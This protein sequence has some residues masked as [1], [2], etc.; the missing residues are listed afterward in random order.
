[1]IPLFTNFFE[2][3]RQGAF[4]D[5]S[6]RTVRHFHNSCPFYQ[7]FVAYTLRFKH[8]V[9]RAR[10]GEDLADKVESFVNDDFLE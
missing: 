2:S 3:R 7:P 9:I 4:L 1:M 8:L 5:I 6:G 10:N